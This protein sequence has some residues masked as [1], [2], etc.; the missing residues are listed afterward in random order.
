MATRVLV[1]FPH[2]PWPPRTGAHRRCLQIL[3]GLVKIGARVHLA[4]TKQFSEQPWTK[5]SISALQIRGLEKVWIHQPFRGQ[6][7]LERWE[8]RLRGRNEWHFC[9]WWLRRWFANL[10]Q[11]IR[12]HSVMITYTLADQLLDH[13]RFSHINRVLE[14]QDLVSVNAQ[15]RLGLVQRVSEFTRTGK[16][17]ELFDTDLRWADNFNPSDEEL[18]ICDRYDA[19]IAIARREQS[20]LEKHLRHARVEWVPMHIPPVKIDN[21]YESP[22]LFLASGNNFNQAG[23]LLLLGE[24]LDR[25][26]AECSDFQLDVVGD[27]LQFAIPTKAVRYMGYIQNLADI[28]GKAAFA[29]C[30]VFSGTGQQ[31]KII[32]AMAHG[33]PV[34][35]FRRAAAESPL[36]HGETGL[37]AANAD[38]FAM[39]LVTLWRNRDLCRRLG[40]A[41]R[42]LMDKP[43]STTTAL[44]GL[45]ANLT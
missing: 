7:R 19:V 14:M 37:V 44:T 41:A 3:D 40:S 4:S 13:A 15:M 29:V 38:E 31:I 6:G 21:S 11:R 45:F 43:D 28:C 25:V 22:P 35:A 32:E 8:A 23:L 39:H 16:V 1:Y 10:I 24:V 2:N 9:S 30:P 34:V 42:A 36:R 5:E 17:G 26:R 33:L 20:L 18:A 27:I 12:P